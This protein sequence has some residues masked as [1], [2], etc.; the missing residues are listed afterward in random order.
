VIRRPDLRDREGGFTL[1]EVLAALIIL[2]VT[3]VGI[4]GALG[5]S[6]ILS[7]VH[8]KA[9]TAD[10]VV[11]TYAERLSNWPYTQCALTNDSHYQPSTLNLTT[12]AQPVIPANF[13]AGTTIVSIKYWNGDTPATWNSTCPGTPPAPC[14]QINYRDCGAQLITVQARSSDGRASQ[15]LTFVK[16][17]L[18]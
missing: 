17:R 12:G 15:L 13:A 4:L 14:V 3:V 10:A 6:T 9:A 8:R 18:Q 7:D 5:S 11:R 1:P 2:G 16:R